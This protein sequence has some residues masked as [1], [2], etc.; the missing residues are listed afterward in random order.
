[1]AICTGSESRVV[2][3]DV[4]P[5]TLKGQRATVYW[6]VEMSIGF[7]SFMLELTDM[8]KWLISE[9][10]RRSLAKCNS[11]SRWRV[12]E[13]LRVSDAGHQTA[14]PISSTVSFHATSCLDEDV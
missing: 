7:L 6:N 9:V 1:M 5:N 8:L 13:S 12:V 4:N 11:P 10:G 3:S 14:D 2:A